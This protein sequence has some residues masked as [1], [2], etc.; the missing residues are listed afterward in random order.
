MSCSREHANASLQWAAR[1][2]LLFFV[3]IGLT[4][5]RAR[6]QDA[7][8]T[9]DERIS[10]PLTLDYTLLETLLE[11]QL[12][13]GPGRSLDVLGGSQ[14]CSDVQLR[15]PELSTQQSELRLITDVRARIGVGAAGNCSVLFSFDGKLGVRGTPEIRASGSALAFSPSSVQLLDS[16][17]QTVSNSALESMAAAGVRRVFD[18]YQIDLKPQLASVGDFIPTVLPRYS[19]EQV[20]ALARTLRVDTLEIGDSAVNASISLEIAPLSAPLEPE[21]PLTEAELAEWE[22]RWQ[23]MDALLVLAVKHY[24]ATT[25]LQDL[26]D[27]LLDALIESRYRLRDALAETPDTGSDAVREW[28]LQSWARLAP[29]LRRIAIEQQGQE[30]LLLVNVITA[31]DALAALDRLGPS[32]GLDISTDGLRRL[33]RMINA[34]E[35]GTLLQYD[36]DVDPALRRLLEESIDGTPPP[37]A[38]RIEWSLFPQAYAADADRLNRWAPQ[39]EDLPEY[40]PSVAA[41]M[42]T[43][44]QSTL[45]ERSLDSRYHTLF[46][47]LVLTTAWQ[48]SCW[49]HY[50][51]SDDRKLV[52]L[53]S[54]TGDV[55]LMQVNERVWRGFYDQQRLRWDIEYNSAA[56]AEVLIDYLTK[57]A[58]RKGEHRQPGGLANLARASYS[59]YNGGP[60][61][62]ARY[63]SSDASAYGKKVDA[64]FWEKYQQVAAG[65]ELAVSTCLGGNLSGRAAALASAPTAAAAG[66]AKEAASATISAERFTLQLGAFSTEEAAKRFVEEQQLKGR[67]E[68][69]ARSAGGSGGYLVLFGAFESRSAAEAASASLGGLKPWIRQFKDL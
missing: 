26:R 24:A 43:T 31:T 61:Q 9:A 6:A 12:F 67:A 1:L 68:V 19:R 23:T 15:S 27:A 45:D 37:S 8:E 33:A 13:T 2:L 59:A 38:W 4:G 14:A 10:V 39:R 62:V 28:F 32:V 11:A 42:D 46:R 41:L 58:L 66:G 21:R 22:E 16:T 47:N 17:G 64:A 30:Q 52:P 51:V 69:R 36:L 53:R 5:T 49:R 65:N 44:I 54:G 3:A 56:G 63:R 50:V 40:L 25:P 29:V 34:G 60:S 48:E 57:Y 7:A 55:G 35:A 18:S 20:E